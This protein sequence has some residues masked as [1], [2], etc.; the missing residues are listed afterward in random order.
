MDGSARA[1]RHLGID[2]RALTRRIR[3]SG[4]PNAVIAHNPEG[5]FDLPAL[6]EKAQAWGA[7]KASISPLS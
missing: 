7:S 6:L 3:V 5:T 1:H 2:T 4:A